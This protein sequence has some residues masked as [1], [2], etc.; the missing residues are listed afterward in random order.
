MIPIQTITHLEHKL[1][2]LI[3]RFLPPEIVI[4]IYSASRGSYLKLLADYASRMPLIEAELNP[5]TLFKNSLLFRNDLGNAAGFDKDGSLLEFNYKIGAGFAIV[6]TTLSESHKGNLISAFGRKVNPWVP[7]SFS[8][9]A[10]NSLGLPNKGIDLAL[11]N[12]KNFRLKFPDS[13]RH[14]PIGLSLMGHPLHNPEQQLAGLLTAIKKASGLVDFIE[15]NESCPNCD[16][17]EDQA[18]FYKRISAIIS[19]RNSIS[20][21]LPIFLKLG[22]LDSVSENIHLFSEL[23]VDGLVLTNTQKNYANFDSQIT[24]T[25]QKL[26]KF[27]T[28][29][30]QGGLSGQAIKAFAESQIRSASQEIQRQNSKLSLIHVGGIQN[31]QDLQSSRKLSSVVLREWYTG[32]LEQMG[33]EAWPKIYPS[34]LASKV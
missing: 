10:L 16:H 4:K 28:S 21:Y 23:Q 8:N 27:Y 26:W 19:L 13:S 20:E 11:Q 17:N 18:L 33:A 32:F 3:A 31:N 5:Q 14:F 22:F 15:I 7:L 34:V 6:G 25:D 2:P 12:I 9:S 1:R 24:S 30:Y 29:K